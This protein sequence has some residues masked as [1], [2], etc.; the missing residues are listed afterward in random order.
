MSP[1]KEKVRELLK[2]LPEGC[3]LEDIQYH[4]YVL[5]KINRG[6]EDL[7]KGKFYTQ[8]EVEKRFSKWLRK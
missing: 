4:L 1:V 8:A 2:Q 6:L 5:Q 3:S 7:K